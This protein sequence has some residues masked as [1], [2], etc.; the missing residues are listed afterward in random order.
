M[1]DD[2]RFK[3]HDSQREITDNVLPKYRDELSN[4]KLWVEKVKKE[5]NEK[6][7]EADVKTNGVDDHVT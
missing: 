5:L 1:I 2:L 4:V 6:I 7:K 3:M